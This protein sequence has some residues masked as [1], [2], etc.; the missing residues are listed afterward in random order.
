MNEIWQWVFLDKN[1]T[2]V[3]SEVTKNTMNCIASNTVYA[4]IKN[5]YFKIGLEVRF[6]N[7]TTYKLETNFNLNCIKFRNS[8]DVRQCMQH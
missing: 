8:V 3:H 5:N 6:L 1:R 2:R 7:S 4:K